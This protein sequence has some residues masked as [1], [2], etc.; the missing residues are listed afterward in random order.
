[1][2][3]SQK[4]TVTENI[5][6]IRLQVILLFLKIENVD[7]LEL[8]RTCLEIENVDY[9]GHLLDDNFFSEGEQSTWSRSSVSKGTGCFSIHLSSYKIECLGV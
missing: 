3:Q 7:Y 9:L 4:Q 5:E 2:S 8:S 6:M 1:M